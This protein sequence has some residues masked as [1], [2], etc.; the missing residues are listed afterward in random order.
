[1]SLK[2]KKK[3]D[4]LPSD[5]MFSHFLIQCSLSSSIIPHTMFYEFFSNF[6]YKYIPVWQ[7]T[8]NNFH[9][10]ETNY[11]TSLKQNQSAET[12]EVISI[13]VC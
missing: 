5:T 12:P 10:L 6:L 3:E 13:V 9:Y 8:I 1:M 11:M 2:K 7:K 4:N